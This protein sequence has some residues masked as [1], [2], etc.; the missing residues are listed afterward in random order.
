MGTMKVRNDMLNGFMMCHGG[1][2]FSLADSILAF[3]SNSY[4]KV[5]V[6][7]E[8]SIAFPN[9]VYEG[10]VLIATSR[11]VSRNEKVGM[12]SISVTKGN[13][14]PVG[15]FRGIVYITKKDIGQ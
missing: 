1:I 11:E 7:I 15:E 12:Y 13:G 6:S 4:G 3:A 2:T 5:A 8:A 14:M 9:P 10:D